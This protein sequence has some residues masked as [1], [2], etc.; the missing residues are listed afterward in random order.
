MTLT[1]TL[2]LGGLAVAALAGAG[3]AQ[4][5]NQAVKARHGLMDLQ[6]YNVGI[7]VA[8]V[9]GTTPYDAALA[10][11]A[12]SNLV[13][14]SGSDWHAY[15]PPG[16]EAGKAEGSAA[17]PAIWQDLDGVWA[18]KQGLM[19]AAAALAGT[20]GDGVDA[21]RTGLGKVGAACSACHE[22]FR[23]PS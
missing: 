17:L 20:A 1:R 13:A 23:Q 15:F 11:A 14:Y 18:K 6:A 4:D 2:L 3:L 16:S 12:A 21:L 7:L 9:K 10:K 22:A 8:M 5:A 19:D